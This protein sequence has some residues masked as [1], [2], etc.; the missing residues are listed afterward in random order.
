M[1]ITHY[2]NRIQPIYKINYTH[3]HKPKEKPEL[4]KSNPKPTESFASILQQIKS[5]L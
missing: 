5:K 3:N 1:K 2:M 4:S